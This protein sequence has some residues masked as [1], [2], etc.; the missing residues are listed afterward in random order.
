MVINTNKTQASI[1][2]NLQCSRVTLLNIRMV[3]NQT[4]LLLQSKQCLKLRKKN[5]RKW[6]IRKTTNE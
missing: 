5:R 2:L 3:P 1:Q 6:P 4:H